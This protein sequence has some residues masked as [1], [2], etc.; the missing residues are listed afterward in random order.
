MY[1]WAP[2]GWKGIFVPLLLSTVDDVGDG[3][4]PWGHC[5]ESGSSSPPG[6]LQCDNEVQLLSL[7][8]NEKFRHPFHYYYFF[9]FL[10]A[11]LC[12]LLACLHCRTEGNAITGPLSQANPASG[13]A[14][15]GK[16]VV[17]ARESLLPDGEGWKTVP[18]GLSQSTALLFSPK[19]E[20]SRSAQGRQCHKIQS[21][22]FVPLASCP[23][24]LPWSGCCDTLP[25]SPLSYPAREA[26]SVLWP[27]KSHT[28]GFLPELS[29]DLPQL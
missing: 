15:G 13:L 14:L 28:G 12:F 23:K 26:P 1:S 5:A 20:K 29:A 21:P 27:S 25:T 17:C 16:A 10:S 7:P 4:W 9:F 22:C 2:I 19:G 8:Q 11:R 24:W 6:G 3:L 18:I